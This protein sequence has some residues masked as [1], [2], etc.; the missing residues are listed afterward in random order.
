VARGPASSATST[1]GGNIAT[2][3]GA[4]RCVKYGVTREAVL[5][6]DVVLADGTLL[7]TGHRSVK[8]VTGYD[9]V[10]L[11]VGSEGTLGIVVGATLRL[12]P[13]PIMVRTLVVSPL[14][15]RAAQPR[16]AREHRRAQR[17][18]PGGTA[19]RRS[20][21]RAGGDRGD[22]PP[23]RRRGERCR[24]RRRRQPAPRPERAAPAG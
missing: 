13:A 20:G 11:M 7:R 15:R 2:N 3:A 4:L 10:G 5:A 1:I 6:L 16:D 21:P 22:R 12:L 19:R 24:A 23:V 18:R 8:G 17:H 9:L 14:H